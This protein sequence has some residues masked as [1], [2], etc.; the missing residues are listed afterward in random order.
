MIRVYCEILFNEVRKDARHTSNEFPPC[1]LEARIC[2]SRLS[3]SIRVK[4]DNQYPSLPARSFGCINYCNGLTLVPLWRMRSL[5]LV[6]FLL[7]RVAKL[8][9]SLSCI[10]SCGDRVSK[11]S[12]ACSDDNFTFFFL[13]IIT[14]FDTTIIII[15]DQFISKLSV[16]R[17][18][19]RKQDVE[20][21][22]VSEIVVFTSILEPNIESTRSWKYTKQR[23]RFPSPP[24]LT[25]S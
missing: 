18:S 15:Y 4:T 24:V 9:L 17:R 5:D 6:N 14:I 1:A 19:A 8:N 16:M 7:L 20:A 21:H 2:P 13:L 23:L 10:I 12:I 22:A 25:C 11:Y 3:E